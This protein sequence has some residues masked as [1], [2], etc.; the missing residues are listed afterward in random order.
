[1]SMPEV[2]PKDFIITRKRKLYKF[3]LFNN[4]RL[5]FEFD[6]WGQ[7]VA[8]VIELG[9]GTGLFSV[10]LA[11][12]YPGK[13]FVAIDVKADRLQTG[14]K[15]AAELNLQ[16][17]VFVRARVE[18]QL[19]TMFKPHS[20]QS[21]WVTFPDPFPKKRASSRR[22]THP[23]FLKI[24]QNLLHGSGALYVKHDNPTFFNWSLEQLV[25]DKWNISEL[26]FDLHD[27]ELSDDYKIQT[28]YEKRWLGEG[29]TTHFVKAF[30]PTLAKPAK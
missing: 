12:R 10:E 5:C 6:E 21:I 14:A 4:S 29:L 19:A 28:T 18:D 25:A 24:Y 17:I 13:Q 15:I 22:M 1:M 11:K 27:S 9:A 26:S 20:L 8:D 23:Q 7:G 30:A 16:N 3:A 2:E